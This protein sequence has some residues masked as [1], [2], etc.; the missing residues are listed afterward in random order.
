MSNYHPEVELNSPMLCISL[1]PDNGVQLQSMNITRR[2]GKPKSKQ[3]I[4]VELRLCPLDHLSPT[5]IHVNIPW[6]KGDPTKV[7]VQVTEIYEIEQEA[8]SFDIRKPKKHTNGRSR[9][10][11][12]GD[13]RN[14]TGHP[15]PILDDSFSNSRGLAGSG[16][17]KNSTGHPKPILDDE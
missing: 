6:K 11:T 14:S 7:E 5:P 13:P 10:L 15:K 9:S 12:S 1:Y 16:D 17:P 2:G 8:M 4:I 3:A